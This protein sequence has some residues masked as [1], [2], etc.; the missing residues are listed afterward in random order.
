MNSYETMSEAQ[1][2]EHLRKRAPIAHAGCAPRVGAIREVLELQKELQRRR[3]AQEA[4]LSDTAS[5]DAAVNASCLAADQ[6]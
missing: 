5:P 1:I 6:T 4:R 3:E 2:H